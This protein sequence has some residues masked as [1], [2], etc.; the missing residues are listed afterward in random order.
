MRSSGG[1]GLIRRT[2]IAGGL[3]AVIVG[4][5]FTIV[6]LAIAELRDW[7]ALARHSEQVLVAANQLE[8]LV[9]DLETGQRGFV[10]TGEESFLEPW[11]AAR[12][13]FPEQARVLERL[14]AASDVDQGRRAQ[15]IA[16]GGAS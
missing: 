11:N 4:T 3:L 9:M 13:S 16:Q 8:R 2:G 15:R 6:L 7:A 12:T 5:A 10:M 1:G 14:A